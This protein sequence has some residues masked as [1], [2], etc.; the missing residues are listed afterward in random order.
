MPNPKDVIWTFEATP[1]KSTQRKAFREGTV[2][3]PYELIG[4]YDGTMWCSC[5]GFGFH[6][7]CRHVQQVIDRFATIAATVRRKAEA[8]LPPHRGY[9]P[10]R[11]KQEAWADLERKGQREIAQRVLNRGMSKRDEPRQG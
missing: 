4:Y 7:D 1:S 2:A 11:L 5:P 3:E 8:E 10:E 6:K 9:D